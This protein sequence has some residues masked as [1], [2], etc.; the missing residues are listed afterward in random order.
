[1]STYI[2]IRNENDLQINNVDNS[3]FPRSVVTA[4]AIVDK[5]PCKDTIVRGDALRCTMQR[6]LAM[7]LMGQAGLGAH[8]DPCGMAEFEKIQ[9]VIPGY[10]I[11]I[12]D[13]GNLKELLYQ[14]EFVRQTYMCD[15]N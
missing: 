3:C 4:K 1:M 10:Q 15:S 11:K 13:S 14:G 9:A 2:C 8:T 7:E 5:H 6:R 12:F